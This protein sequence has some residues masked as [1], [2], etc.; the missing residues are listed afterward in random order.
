MFSWKKVKLCVF[1][2]ILLTLLNSCLRFPRNEPPIFIPFTLE[3][4]RMVIYAEVNGVKGRFMWDTGSFDSQTL[5]STSL[6]NLTPLPRIR[7][8]TTTERRY[9]I[10][11][12]IVINE[13]IIRSRSIINY[14]HSHPSPNM[15]K[16]AQ[17]LLEEGFDGILG[18]AMF[19]GWWVEVSFTTNNI[20][21]HRQKPVGF[22]NYAPARTTF[23]GLYRNPNGRFFVTGIVDD[24]PIDFWVDT[25]S[26][27]TFNFPHSMREI[28]GTGYRKTLLWR[29]RIFYE[30]CTSNISLMGDV[31]LDK[32]IATCNWADWFAETESTQAILGMDFLQRYDLLFDMRTLNPRRERTRLYYRQ[33]PEKANTEPFLRS[34]FASISEPFG[35]RLESQEEGRWLWVSAVTSPGFAHDELGLMPGMTITAINGQP[36]TGADR[37]QLYDFLSYLKDGGH[38][39]LSVWVDGAKRVITR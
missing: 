8:R 7:N 25:G 9:Y 38:G 37:T 32:A 22:Y 33:R 17:S 13:Q 5:N 16:M 12:G 2:F 4:N 28:L 36:I 29:E 21:L 10:E 6:E 20:I 24:M 23:R 18:I 11:N 26:P 39:E 3:N 19:N 35:L 14:F 30:I 31:F 27:G 34:I 15:E 1:F